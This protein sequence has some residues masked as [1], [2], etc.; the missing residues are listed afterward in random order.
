MFFSVGLEAVHFR[1]QIDETS[2]NMLSMT[3]G[4]LEFI[5]FVFEYYNFRFSSIKWMFL[6]WMFL[7]VIFWAR[8]SPGNPHMKIT[9]FLFAFSAFTRYERMVVYF[10]HV[11]YFDLFHIGFNF[12]FARVVKWNY[13]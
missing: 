6:K 9:Y 3:L 5:I 7:K 4:C 11:V 12:C 8:K 10:E 13:G 2:M 1:G